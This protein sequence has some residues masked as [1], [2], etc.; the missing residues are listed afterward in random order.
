MTKHRMVI[1]LH[2]VVPLDGVCGGCMIGKH[3]Q[4]TFGIGKS[5]REKTKLEL[6]HSDLYSLN[7]PSLVGAWYLLTLIDDLTKYT[8]VYFLKNKSCVFEKFK[9]FRALVEE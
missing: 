8:W 5:W 6:V 9:E 4:A 3:N 1:V 2:K 7:K